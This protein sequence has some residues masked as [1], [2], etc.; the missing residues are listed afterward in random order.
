MKSDKKVVIDLR[1][2]LL[3]KRPACTNTKATGGE[4]LRV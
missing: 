4:W 1:I 3:M 2:I